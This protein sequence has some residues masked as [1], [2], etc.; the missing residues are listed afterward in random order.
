[1]GAI[2]S[3][4]SSLPIIGSLFPNSDQE[5]LRNRMLGAAQSYS[6]MRPAEAEAR[7]QATQNQMGAYRGVQGVLSQMNGGRGGPDMQ[8]L[9]RNPVT[10]AMTGVGAVGVEDR[11]ASASDAARGALNGAGAGAAVGAPFGGVGAG[12]GGGVGAVAGA[13]GALGKA[14]N[15]VTFGR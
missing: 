1:M 13:L 10:P 6:A 15:K 5:E 4:L 12:I 14:R 2:T 9:S 7:H 3:A 11:S 8:A